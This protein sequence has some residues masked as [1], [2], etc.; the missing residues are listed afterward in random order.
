[1]YAYITI[2]QGF[3]ALRV[4]QKLLLAPAVFGSLTSGMKLEQN[5]YSS[6]AFGG[7]RIYGLEQARRIDR[8]YQR[9][10]WRDIFYLVGLQRTYEVPLYIFRKLLVFGFELLRA[11]LAESTLTASVSGR[12]VRGRKGFGDGHELYICGQSGFYGCYILFYRHK[13]LTLHSRTGFRRCKTNAV[14]TGGPDR[15][16]FIAAVFTCFR[17]L[18]PENNLR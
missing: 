10:V 17:Y 3:A 9:Y 7:L 4:H 11:V 15:T 18:N 14:P 1:M 12:Y 6:S 5:V 16:D 8:M 2:F 13:S